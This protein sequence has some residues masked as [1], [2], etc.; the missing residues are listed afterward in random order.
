M[1][2]RPILIAVAGDVSEQIHAFAADLGAELRGVHARV[3]RGSGSVVS[4]TLRAAFD[5]TVWLEGEGVAPE[6]RLADL[7]VRYDGGVWIVARDGTV[8]GARDAVRFVADRARALG[9]RAGAAA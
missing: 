9:A 1:P 2:T 5:L 6:A 3:V 8:V 4:R 7:R